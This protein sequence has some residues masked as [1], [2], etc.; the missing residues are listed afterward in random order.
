MYSRFI[1]RVLD[2]ILS[3]V[4][5]IILSPVIVITLLVT[6][7]HLGRPL[8]DVRFPREG[9]NKKP[10]YMLKFRTRVYDNGDLWGRKTKLS[11]LM[12][13]LKLNELPQLFNILKG[14]MSFVGPRPF[15]CGEKL[16]TGRI[17]PK[18]YYVRPGVTGLFQVKNGKSHSEKLKYDV[19]YYDNMGFIFDL[20][21]L[22]KT[23]VSIIKKLNS[24]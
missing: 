18:R 15:I 9:K 11:M 14:D 13:N 23:P 4:L 17:S 2:I 12:D 7:L 5:I 8:F 16:P 24:K 3:L 21:I 1:K 20:G 6:L 22:L 19:E 10:F